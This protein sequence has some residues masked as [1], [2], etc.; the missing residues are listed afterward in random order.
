VYGYIHGRCGG[1]DDLA[2]ELTQLTF[3]EAVRARTSFV[4][5]SEPFTWLCSIA[6]HKLADHYRRLDQEERRFLRLVIEER[7]PFG[8]EA[9]WPGGD[10][11]EAVNTALRSLPAMQCAA[12]VFRYLDGLSVRQTAAMIGRT[13]SAT[14]SLLSRARD[15][16]RRAYQEPSD[17]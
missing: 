6:R 14:E 9:A 17:G 15:N 3:T 7:P 16:F 10:R 4:G 8:A 2:E 1:D 5:Q 13:E 12:L 11:R